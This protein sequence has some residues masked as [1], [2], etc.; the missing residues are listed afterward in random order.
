MY[1]YKYVSIKRRFE[2]VA[3]VLYGKRIAF[4]MPIYSLLFHFRDEYI[5]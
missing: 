3:Y 2:R 5:P 1:N 4:S